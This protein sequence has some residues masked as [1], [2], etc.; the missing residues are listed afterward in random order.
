[1]TER[2]Q[3]V[4]DFIKAYMRIHGVGP[5]YEI[6]AKGLKMRSRANMHRIVMRLEKEGYLETKSRKFYSIRVIDKSVKE[7]SAL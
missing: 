7:V 3:V 6:L 4:L 5:S 1:M 2:W